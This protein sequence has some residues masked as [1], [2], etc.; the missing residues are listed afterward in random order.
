MLP[1]E[2]H[3]EESSKSEIESDEEELGMETDTPQ[4]SFYA[5]DASQFKVPTQGRAVQVK[6]STTQ[7]SLQ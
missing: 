7:P 1:V 4:S 3:D 5:I 2:A 6:F